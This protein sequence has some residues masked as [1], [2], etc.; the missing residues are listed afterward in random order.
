MEKLKRKT[1]YLI[2]TVIIL[3]IGIISLCSTSNAEIAL[4][5]EDFPHKR[6]WA[7]FQHPGTFHARLRGRDH[8]DLTSY[9]YD[10]EYT[11][12]VQ[13]NPV[14][15]YC[16]KE[17]CPRTATEG[18]HA[19]YKGWG[20]WG[21]TATRKLEGLTG[22]VGIGTIPPALTSELEITNYFKD[23]SM[24]WIDSST[25]SDG[26]KSAD[27]RAVAWVLWHHTGWKGPSQSW[28]WQFHELVQSVINSGTTRKPDKLAPKLENTRRGKTS[29]VR[30][31][32]NIHNPIATTTKVSENS[33]PEPEPEPTPFDPEVVD[34]SMS[35]N[36][37]WYIEN[38]EVNGLKKYLNDTNEPKL[39]NTGAKPVQSDNA[40]WV[41]PFKID[42]DDI[43]K[44][45][46]FTD[47]NDSGINAVSKIV[48]MKVEYLDGTS[49]DATIK[50]NDKTITDL[51][52]L[53]KEV[54][55]YVKNPH[56]EK[57]VTNLH[58]ELEKCA[59]YFAVSAGVCD[60]IRTFP[61]EPYETQ[62]KLDKWAEEKYKATIEGLLASVTNDYKEGDYKPTNPSRKVVEKS[63]KTSYTIYKPQTLLRIEREESYRIEAWYMG[64]D[65]PVKAYKADIELEKKGN[66]NGEEK[67]LLDGIKF[68]VYCDPC[69]YI[70]DI[71]SNSK[72]SHGWEIVFTNNFNEA[73]LWITRNG[74]V[75]IPYLFTGDFYTYRL[76]EV[77]AEDTSD[78][79]YYRDKFRLSKVTPT[80]SLG[81]ITEGGKTY[82][83]V[84]GLKLPS[85]GKI[86][87]TVTNDRSSGDLILDKFDEKDGTKLKNARFKIQLV[88]SE[89]TAEPEHDLNESG[90]LNPNAAKVG[91]GIYDFT[92]VLHDKYID[93]CEGKD[94]GEFVTDENGHL[95]LKGILNGTYHIYETKG[96]WGYDIEGQTDEEGIKH[97]YDEKEYW[98]DITEVQVLSTSKNKVTYGVPNIRTRGNIKIKKVDYDTGKPL[99]DA[100]FK[101]KLVGDTDVRGYDRYAN[102]WLMGQ[103]GDD[104]LE[105]HFKEFL[106]PDFAKG[107]VFKT[108]ENGEIN[109]KNIPLGKY[110]IYET[111]GAIGHDIEGQ[112]GD[113]HDYDYVVEGENKKYVKFAEL[114]VVKDGYATNE[115][116]LHNDLTR[117]KL[118]MEKSD[119]IYRDKEDLRKLEGAKFIF[120]LEELTDCE[121]G[122]KRGKDVDTTGWIRDG[123]N[124]GNDF[125]EKEL[126]DILTS[127]VHEAGIYET[128]ENGKIIIT[129]IPNGTYHIYEI[130]MPVGYNMEEQDGYV[131][132][133]YGGDKDWVD[134]GTIQVDSFKAE[135]E[136]EDSKQR[137]S[138]VEKEKTFVEILNRHIIDQKDGL[139]GFVW[140][141]KPGESKEGI[142][143][144]NYNS[145]YD[146]GEETL[147][148]INVTLKNAA[149]E[150]MAS[151]V[152]GDGG[153]Y[154][155]AKWDADVPKE[156]HVDP[157]KEE[158]Y[159]WDLENAYV[160]FEYNDTTYVCVHPFEGGSDKVVINSKAQKD[161]MTAENLNDKN[162][163]VDYAITKQNGEVGMSR[164]EMRTTKY[165]SGE[166]SS[167]GLMAYYNDNNHIVEN[168]N[169]GL[170]EK[171]DP[172][173]KVW[174]DIQYSKVKIRGYTY[175]YDYGTYDEEGNY[176]DGTQGKL[177]ADNTPELTA[178]FQ[179][180]ATVYGAEVYPSDIAYTQ[181][182]LEDKLG[183][184]LEGNGMEMYVVYKISI[185]NTTTTQLENIYNEKALFL[186]NLWNTYDS[187]R[188]EIS[189]DNTGEN[190]WKE[191][192]GYKGSEY[193]AGWSGGD[194]TATYDLNDHQLGDREETKNSDKL[195]DGIESGQTKCVYIQFKVK[196]S[197]LNNML[198][199]NIEILEKQ[200]QKAATIA[201][202]D[203][204]HV[205]YRNDNLWNG[206]VERY[207]GDPND[208][209]HHDINA[210]IESYTGKYLHRSLNEQHDSGSLALVIKLAD[211]RT[212]KGSV[213]EDLEELKLK[214][215]TP[216]VN[217]P[218][219]V[220]EAL[221]N[222]IIDD[223]T[224]EGH[225]VA[226][227]NRVEHIKIELIDA[228]EKDNDGK[229]HEKVLS[230]DEE[231]VKNIKPTLIFGDFM[232]NG[233]YQ[234][235]EAETHSDSHGNY[236]FAGIVPGLYYLRFTYPDNNEETKTILVDK[237]GNKIED[238]KT[239]D[240]KS[241]IIN[242]EEGKAGDIIKNAM[243]TQYSDMKNYLNNNK[244]VQETVQEKEIQDLVQQYTEWYKYMNSDTYNI[245]SDDIKRRNSLGNYEYLQDVDENQQTYTDIKVSDDEA[246]VRDD[247]FTF[248]DVWSYTPYFSI[249]VENTEVPKAT[250]SF[251]GDGSH[252]WEYKG[253]NLGL[254]KTPITDIRIDKM[255][256]N[257]KLTNSVGTTLSNNKPMEPT[258]YV[259]ALDNLE[260]GSKYS[261]V[262]MALQE[263]YGSAIE[264]TYTITLTNLSEQDFIEDESVDGILN[265][266]FGYYFKYG[267]SENANS[268]ETTITEVIDLSDPD[269]KLDNYLDKQSIYGLK[270]HLN[271]SDK[272]EE[273][274]NVKA[275]LKST[276]EDDPEDDPERK[277]KEWVTNLEGKKD[278]DKYLSIEGFSSFEAGEEIVFSYTVGTRLE[279]NMDMLLNNDATTAR[280]KM[281]TGATLRTG[282]K[283]ED[284]YT[285]TDIVMTPDTGGDRRHINYIAITLGLIV[286][287]GGIVFIKKVILK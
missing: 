247:A 43:N 177:T 10:L 38:E 25:G 238:I 86:A 33:T 84:E 229:D 232:G 53:K 97:V 116:K 167:H 108:D 198:N 225:V 65:I 148:G 16:E 120:F 168:I 259:A 91:N 74:K 113:E 60:G 161:I 245:G 45:K 109:L 32:F 208:D 217:E 138:K 170:W 131:Q 172:T 280:F 179:E 87:I 256:T 110:E 283:W 160:E 6:Q 78:N 150:R 102:G 224:A 96:D 252:Q 195:S 254:I 249:T 133:G 144:A 183:G 99:K 154:N 85:N 54:D 189:A 12:Q 176:E 107:G 184:K 92:G 15:Y 220:H 56:P 222:G 37:D 127:D 21:D 196:Q 200:M 209:K 164:D 4:K 188:F 273:Q 151:T 83:T 18:K 5:W 117:G 80:G 230:E 8:L 95:E 66:Y 90:W 236:E 79:H 93:H 211:T 235:Q 243:E 205:Y 165:T 191:K 274:I 201:Y 275:V 215:D 3:F 265:G 39:E 246:A 105:R 233:I 174:Q 106:T 185:R 186:D 203:A 257:I 111:K 180:G 64:L 48:E 228:E 281:D 77:D 88:R 234:G 27:A 231:V 114:F 264:T 287:V 134:F 268:K 58:I 240:Y 207:R 69:G 46:E 63:M 7:C 270:K 193:F 263:I 147:S 194:G 140:V 278:Y 267:K 17:E 19:H 192:E 31:D 255:I 11:Y 139:V 190:K 121:G 244:M 26:S 261:R 155:I 47:V 149:G 157:E 173:Y 103:N 68:A 227:E 262:E 143:D 210:T 277:F 182:K 100:E 62:D 137:Q 204:Y 30:N 70:K 24:R 41:G 156:K 112:H 51:K 242:T 14:D 9:T 159:L 35:E 94:A 98:V 212:I 52:E 49:E 29:G 152:T 40:E 251:D 13:S 146:E 2:S 219:E 126:K 118:E 23:P 141:D 214:G 197:F 163:N 82:C 81:H 130:E 286:L 44:E 213:Y 55:F 276:T 34:P 178:Y 71:K 22:S 260:G 115:R 258:E 266:E 104:Y 279:A 162:L 216:E 73:K 285:D 67:D 253:F 248:K 272:P 61:S 132:N 206:G 153:R 125:T 101:I 1:R 57:E 76:I 202:T 226:E 122:A 181:Q 269:Y 128:D 218:D 271:E 135:K 42:Y 237:D 75:T 59:I 221:G 158:L 171:I 284:R 28:I 36:T 123:N 223:G 175:T 136:G 239:N 129:G 250:V 89:K 282:F 124:L 50:Q 142:T 169:L 166:L 241:T 187:E 72:A 145:L 20:Y 199:G 119:Y